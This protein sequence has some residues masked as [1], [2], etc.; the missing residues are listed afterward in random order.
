MAGKVQ[1][2]AS[3]L[4]TE[5]LTSNP[6]FSYF[7]V[8]FSKHSNFASDTISLKPDNEKKVKTGDYIEF[9]IPSNN[10]D[11]LNRMSFSFSIPENL[12]EYNTN[13]QNTSLVDQFAVSIFEYIELYLGEQLLDR[14]TSDD[15]NIY[16]VTREASTYALTN[17]CIQGGKFR[18]VT[19]Q[20][21]SV[22]SSAS[23][24]FLTSQYWVNGQFKRTNE[25]YYGG[26]SS[27]N[28]S[29]TNN[30]VFRNFIVNIPFYF[31]DRP[32]NAFPLC[33][34][35]YQ[36]LKIRVKLREGKEVV[37]PSNSSKNI[38]SV[39]A[40][41][42]YQNDSKTTNFPLSKFKLNLDVT[43]LDKRERNRMTSNCVDIL[44]EQNQHERFTMRR[45]IKSQTYRLNFKNCVKELY[46]IAKK[47]H[48]DL[49]SLEN[50][51]LSAIY[52]T[53]IASYGGLGLPHRPHPNW[54]NTF[55]GSKVFQKPVPCIYMRQKHVT[56][57]LDGIPILDETIGSHQF[58]STCIPNVYHKQAPIE[59]NLTMYSFALRPDKIEP[60]GEINFTMIKDAII[61][62]TLSSDGSYG[63]YNI[64][65]ELLDT[66]PSLIVHIEK[67]ILVIAKSYNV[68]RIKDGVGKILF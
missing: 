48:K 5:Q 64:F 47:K 56:L 17:D 43:Y 28:T 25:R 29:Q 54:N 37:F 38:Q 60:S 30:I 24:M 44:F 59:N 63:L 57:S 65:N 39:E 42:D 31:H 21:N 9:S 6:E 12:S 32:K 45:G 11:I 61:Q 62:M 40:E 10:G 52:N 4:L 14:V 68:L 18:P 20:G 16:H 7:N 13:T 50:N 53:N 55:V 51:I 23:R 2:A 33:S 46:F 66:S 58:L 3:G 27:W 15:I 36:E 49:T 34:I 35:R 26:P 67:E 19:E 41:W 1:I 22:P 8:F